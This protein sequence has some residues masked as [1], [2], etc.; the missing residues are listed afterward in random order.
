MSNSKQRIL[1][2]QLI[3][4]QPEPNLF[5]FDVEPA[6]VCEDPKT[7]A[8]AIDACLNHMSG[9]ENILSRFQPESQLSRLN[10]YGEFTES[11]PA[12]LNLVAKSLELSQLTDGAFDIT[13]KPLLDLY[14]ATPGFLPSTSQID[15]A[16]K[17]VDYHK[18]DLVGQRITF[19]SLVCPSRWMEL[20][21]VL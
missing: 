3:L 17:L 12:L 10:R 9:L 1:F 13:V 8:S 4:A 11:H 5:L 19:S 7:A 14:Q 18:M 6:V 16:L 21:K 2:Q 20:P 15:Q